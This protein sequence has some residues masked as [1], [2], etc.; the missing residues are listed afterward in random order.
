MLQRYEW[1]DS[2]IEAQ[3]DGI[4]SNGALM[5]AVKLARAINWNP[6]RAERTEPGLYW[7]NDDAFEAVGL[8]RSTFY[9]HRSE[10]F[11]TGFF[12][13]VR[14]NLVPRLGQST[15]R[16]AESTVETNESQEETAQSQGGQPFSEDTFTVNTWSE[17]AISE[18]DE[19]SAS[20]RP[21]RFTPS[22]TSSG[23]PHDSG[24]SLADSD[25]PSLDLVEDARESLLG[26]GG[27]ESETRLASEGVR[28]LS[29]EIW[30]DEKWRYRATE[31]ENREVWGLLLDPSFSPDRKPSDRVDA[32]IAHLGL[33]RLPELA[34]LD[35]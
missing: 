21:H 33:E 5:A 34:D 29:I 19:A 7:K 15:L 22:L 18:D 2:L 1:E 20:P 12:D 35:W 25:D 28:R 23:Y 24:R 26:T 6:T 3:K 14:G 27:E 10:L 8:G 32:V 13:T 9:R 11:D 16:T 31:D 30:R 4:I 17:D